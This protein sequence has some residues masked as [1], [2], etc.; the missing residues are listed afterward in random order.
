MAASTARRLS[1]ETRAV[2]FR[3]RETV[4]GDTPALR[5][6]SISV[7]GPEER[8]VSA[9]TVPFDYVLKTFAAEG[10]HKFTVPPP[11]CCGA[12]TFNVCRVLMK[13]TLENVFIKRRD[14]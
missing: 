13:N 14:I 9:K 1:S 11:I 3:I 2:P 7:D 6:T 12:L 8:G 4:L 5:A 10:Y